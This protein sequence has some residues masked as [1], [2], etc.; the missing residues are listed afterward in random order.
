MEWSTYWQDNSL[1]GTCCLQLLYSQ[2]YT[3]GGTSNN[4]LARAIEIYGLNRAFSGN[5]LTN[6]YNLSTIHT[7]NS[8]HAALSYRYSL[9]HVGTSLVYQSNCILEVQNASCHQSRI[10]TQA[11]TTSNLWLNAIFFQNLIGNAAN[12]QNSWLSI[13]SQLQVLLRPLE[14]HLHDG[15]AKSLI[16]L[17]E[18]LLC[19][20]IVVIEILAHANLLCTLSWEYKS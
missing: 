11:M 16:G 14:A 1:L 20:I 19:H 4:D 5:L 10:F 2:L 15:I 13:S 6:L 7:D 8:S 3:L 9:L 18:R 12:G 17:L